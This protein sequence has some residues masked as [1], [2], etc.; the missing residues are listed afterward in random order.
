MVNRPG[1]G[2]Q[3]H[4]TSGVYVCDAAP[5]PGANRR[6]SP[7]RRRHNRAATSSATSVTA[8]PSTAIASP[9]PDQEM[10]NVN[11]AGFSFDVVRVYQRN[12]GGQWPL[13]ASLGAPAPSTR[14]IHRPPSPS[15]CAASACWS[16]GAP[17]RTTSTPEPC[18]R[19]TCSNMAARAGRARKPCRPTI[20][21]MAGWTALTSNSGLAPGFGDRTNDVGGIGFD[22]AG[23]ALVAAP[24]DKLVVPLRLE[25]RTRPAQYTF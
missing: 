23:A 20:G 24:L 4:S 16:G 18:P 21:R 1:G 17:F 3:Q 9:D 10:R 13:T 6:R 15:R 2:C 14:A 11:G 7:S 8:S 22:D 19:F 25:L 5:V 12:G